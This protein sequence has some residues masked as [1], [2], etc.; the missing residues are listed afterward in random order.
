[1][2]RH[3]N[4]RRVV[5]YIMLTKI[6]GGLRI[7]TKIVLAMKA[8]GTLR[9]RFGLR[10]TAASKLSLLLIREL[11]NRTNHTSIQQIYEIHSIHVEEPALALTPCGA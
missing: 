5:K 6:F 8:L 3:G 1:M 11:H 7:I 4:K 10:K 9:G 2:C